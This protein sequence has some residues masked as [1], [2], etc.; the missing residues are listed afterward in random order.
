LG[1]LRYRILSFANRDTLTISLPIYIPFIS[2][3]CLIALGSNS[4]TML[5]RSGESGHTSLV[6]HF[7]ENGFSFSPLSMMEAI[8]S[9]HIAFIM[10]SY[11]P[12]IPSFLRAFVM[13]W[14]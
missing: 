4:K 3:S 9:S 11:I 12:S 6:P 2:S 8:G 10:L 5:N 13:K 14:C 7:R 1:S